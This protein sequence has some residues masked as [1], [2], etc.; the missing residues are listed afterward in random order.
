M[1]TCPNCKTAMAPEQTVCPS[2]GTGLSAQSGN[3]IAALCYLGFFIT[4]LIFLLAEPYNR[5]QLVRF[6]AR[7]SI[8]FSVA[9]FAFYIIMSV[10]IAVMPGPISKLFALIASLG[11]IALAFVWVFLM[12]QAYQGIRFKIPVLA[13]WA[14]TIPL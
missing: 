10:F 9:W 8:A 1:A 7:Q 6:H 4:G 2:C 14:E 5:D 11:Y 3:V 13:E 12:Y